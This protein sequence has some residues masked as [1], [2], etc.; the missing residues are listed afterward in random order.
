MDLKTIME[1]LDL[2]E[3][4]T[5]AAEPVRKYEKKSD[6]VY[7]P[8]QA[9]FKAVI[10][11][12]NNFIRYYY[13]YD[14]VTYNKVRHVDE[15]E[16]L[17]KLLRLIK[18]FEGTYKNAIIYA[19]LDTDRNV[20]ADYTHQVVFFNMFGTYTTNKAVTFKAEEKNNILNVEH[21]KV[22]GQRVINK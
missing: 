13:S 10:Y 9:R 5:E 18:K 15:F 12:K 22:Y 2:R 20:K 21:L 17:K 14:N 7:K 19:T 1:G 4:L 8:E 11:F 6:N 3:A 16:G